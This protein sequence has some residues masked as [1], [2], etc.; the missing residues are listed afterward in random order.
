MLMLLCCI[1]CVATLVL[2]L[3]CM[4]VLHVSD[5]MS[6]DSFTIGL[7]CCDCCGMRI[8][9]DA[10]S[11]RDSFYMIVINASTRV[12]FISTTTIIIIITTLSINRLLNII[13]ISL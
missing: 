12:I 3:C 5:T 7:D 9:S 2:M 8:L 1:T 13:D 6:Y 11:G 4:T 10:S